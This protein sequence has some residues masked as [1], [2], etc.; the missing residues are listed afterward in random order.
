M[1]QHSVH[2]NDN[3]VV[4]GDECRRLGIGD[5]CAR[6][7]CQIDGTSNGRKGVILRYHI[8]LFPVKAD[9]LQE[10]PECQYAG[11]PGVRIAEGTMPIGPK[12]TELWRCPCVPFI[13]PGAPYSE[14]PSVPA[15]DRLR[16]A[17]AAI[18]R[19]SGQ[20]DL[21]ETGFQ[22]ITKWDRIRAN[23]VL[24]YSLV[25]YRIQAR[26]VNTYYLTCK[27][28]LVWFI[29]DIVSEQ[30]GRHIITIVKL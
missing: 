6:M 28:G 27:N 24:T 15:S 18:M 2:D 7:V 25:R 13:R 12:P 10:S 1:I 17:I 5:F 29:T 19:N 14:I 16:A 21:V 26:N 22:A 9:D 11:W 3:R 23:P 4:L 8:F 20:P 30:Q